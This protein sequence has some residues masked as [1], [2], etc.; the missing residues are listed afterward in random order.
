M[1]LEQINELQQKIERLNQTFL[2]LIDEPFE[3]HQLWRQTYD[4]FQY[5]DW[6]RLWGASFGVK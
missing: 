4:E 6:A 3:Q 5:R 1:I 2:N